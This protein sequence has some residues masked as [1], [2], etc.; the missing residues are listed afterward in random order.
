MQ[1]VPQEKRRICVTTIHPNAHVLA[2]FPYA[3]HSS[4][5]DFLW[6]EPE[7]LGA[8]QILLALITVGLGAIFAVT[9][10]GVSQDF[11]L[12]LL[13]GYPF[14][15]PAVFIVAGFLTL[16]DKTLKSKLVS[17]FCDFCLISLLSSF[18]LIS[19]RKAFDAKVLAGSRYAPRGRS[20]HSSLPAQPLLPP[21]TCSFFPQVNGNSCLSA[22]W[23]PFYIPRQSV[24]PMNIVSSLAAPAGVILSVVSYTQQHKLC[25]RPSLEGMCVV[26]RT[27]LLGLLSILFIISIM[28]FSIAV[29]IMS[30]R[31]RC[32]AQA[33]EI[34]FFLPSDVTKKSQQPVQEENAQLQF[35]LQNDSSHFD[36]P[37]HTKTVFFGSYA[38]FKLIHSRSPLASQDRSP[39]CK[40]RPAL[41]PNGQDDLPLH[42]KLSA[43]KIELKPLLYTSEVRSPENVHRHRVSTEEQL[44]DEDLEYAVVHTS[45]EQAQKF[46]EQDLPP[47]AFPSPPA[48]ILPAVGVLPPKSLLM[49]APPVQDMPSKSSSF[50]II[51]PSNLTYKDS[52]SKD[53]QSQESRSKQSPHPDLKEEN[54]QAQ[55]QQ[56]SE[57]IYQDILTEVVELTQE[58]KSKEKPNYTKSS[59]REL[60]LNHRNK[61]GKSP[62]SLSLSPQAKRGK[63]PRRKSLYQKI[64]ALLFTKKHS[65]DQKSQYTQTSEQFLDQHTEDWPAK[66]DQAEGAPMQ[67]RQDS[68]QTASQSPHWS[69]S[70]SLS[71]AQQSQDYGSQG[72]KNKDWKV[73][74]RQHERQ[75]SLNWESQELL[76]KGALKQSSLYQKVQTQNT[77]AQHGLGWQFQDQQHWDKDQDFQSRMM[78]KNTMQIVSLQTRDIS[79]KGMN[80]RDQKPTDTQS[81]DTE[82]DYRP[83][84]S[85]SVVQDTYPT[86][87]SNMDFEQ[88]TSVCSGS[89]KD[90]LNVHSISSSLKDDQQQ[91]EDSG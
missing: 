44:K 86:C 34:V 18:H 3:P 9:S 73:Q 64:R 85:Q 63:S 67:P 32:W 26:G 5:L 19:M 65:I 80:H 33:D 59:G 29:T 42:V 31:S 83:S 24:T 48:E 49:Q 84:S 8:V 89:T 37:L 71:F 2:G 69:P 72:W 79:L 46:Q 75:R 61:G 77:I 68:R 58:W 14:W 41:S 13:T 45:K 74:E 1:S 39:P 27:L 66:G 36:I 30:F 40:E 76:V 4:L 7:L 57:I 87:L 90:D 62:R 55:M 23:K 28:E 35:D 20:A 11:P 38:F 25:Q 50:H 22:C 10:T 53:K 56:F 60:S 52:S 12:L 82:P 21:S 78:L 81:E 54:I 91:S 51:E 47:Q 17:R 16:T 43:G 6:G 15:G 70:D 88:N